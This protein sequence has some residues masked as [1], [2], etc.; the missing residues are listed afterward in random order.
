MSE[1]A[2]PRGLPRRL[3]VP[4]LSRAPAGALPAGT[5][6]SLAASQLKRPSACSPP[7]L[8]A[9]PRARLLCAASRSVPPAARSRVPAGSP[10]RIALL[11][12]ALGGC[13][14]RRR[15]KQVVLFL[16]FSKVKFIFQTR[17]CVT[18]VYQ[19]SLVL[20]PCQAAADCCEVNWA[21]VGLPFGSVRVL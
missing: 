7:P 15:S 5:A 4:S 11:P 12:P 2:W 16:F 6:W 13:Y 9:E 17:V 20:L 19:N 21:A 8:G 1:R 14:C 3:Q 18:R 10:L